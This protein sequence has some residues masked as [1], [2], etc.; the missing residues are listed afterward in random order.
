MDTQDPNTIIDNLG[1]TSAVARIFNISPS[2]VTGWRTEGIPDAR[3]M[4]LEVVY[5]KAFKAQAPATN[6][7]P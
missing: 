3:R 6:A 5:P 7:N 2:S 1:G 4:Y